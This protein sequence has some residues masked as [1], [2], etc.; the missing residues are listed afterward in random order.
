MALKPEIGRGSEFCSWYEYTGNVSLSQPRRMGLPTG[1][2]PTQVGLHGGWW[3]IGPMKNI[4]QSCLLL[5]KSPKDI[6]PTP[7]QKQSDFPRFIIIESLQDVKLDQL[8][9]FLIEKII[10]TRSTPKTVKKLQTEKPACGSG[11]QKTCWKPIRNGEISE[12]QMSCL[13]TRQIKYLQWC[14]E[15]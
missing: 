5:S 13:S 7:T 2:F 14:C 12:S 8:S 6:Y 4:H 10:S 15:K 9:P 3:S 1:L 11:K